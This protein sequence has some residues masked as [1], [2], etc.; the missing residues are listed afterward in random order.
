MRLKIS[1]MNRFWLVGLVGFF[2]FLDIKFHQ[3]NRHSP[4]TNLAPILMNTS[5]NGTISPQGADQR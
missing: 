4:G 3:N 2:F 5:T 1:P